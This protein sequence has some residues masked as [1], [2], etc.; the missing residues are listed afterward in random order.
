M[1]KLRAP[2]SFE[3]ALAKIAG[4]IGWEAAARIAGQSER[5]VRNWSDPD[6][7][8]GIRLDAA[9]KL[10]VAYRAAGGDGAPMFQCYALRLEA[11]TEAACADSAALCQ[12]TALAAKEAGEAVSAL[13][14][15]SR[16]GASHSDRVVAARETEEALGALTSSLSLLG[17]VPAHATSDSERPARGG[18]R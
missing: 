8:A 18:D 12:A 7:E 17:P 6:T 14:M 2:C 11:E 1:T 13:V 16:P 3:N 15:A 4:V 9:L 5:C 10:D